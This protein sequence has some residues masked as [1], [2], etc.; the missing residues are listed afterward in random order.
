MPALKGK[1]KQLTDEESNDSRLVIK[2]RWVVEAFHGN[3]KQKFK[4]LNNVI[5]NKLLPKVSLYFRIAAFLHNTF[6]KRLES[7]LELSDEIVLRMKNQ[8]SVENSYNKE[9]EKKV[10]IE[11]KLFL[12]KLR[13]TTYL[14]FQ[15]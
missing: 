13:L 2:I 14:I 4:L 6:G 11:K 1:R 15:K 5:D 3:I 9:I 10:G 12:K 7:D 8:K